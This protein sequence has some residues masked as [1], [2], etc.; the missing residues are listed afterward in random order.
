L[1]QPFPRVF[2]CVDA[3]LLTLVIRLNYVLRTQTGRESS[4]IH[5]TAVTSSRRYLIWIGSE[6]AKTF[7]PTI[8]GL[9]RRHIGRE[10]ITIWDSKYQGRYRPLS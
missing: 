10:R 4:R 8:S 3:C 6:Q 9:I 1:A 5:H 2:R 7:G